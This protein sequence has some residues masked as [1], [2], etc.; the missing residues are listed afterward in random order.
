MVFAT[1]TPLDIPTGP[2]RGLATVSDLPVLRLAVEKTSDIE[3]PLEPPMPPD[4]ETSERSRT[5][6][7][8]IIR[9]KRRKSRT[10]GSDS[11]FVLRPISGGSSFGALQLRFKEEKFGSSK[12]KL[13]LSP[14]AALDGI[15]G[16]SEAAIRRITRRRISVS[17]RSH[18]SSLRESDAVS[19]QA[20][21]SMPTSFGLDIVD[22]NLPLPLLTKFANTL[23]Q[24][25]HS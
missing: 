21:S 17:G 11:P 6:L 22:E 24:P 2:K 4:P 14:Y 23:E 13:H 25:H 12:R 10:V 9:A 15:G 3:G 20:Q 7:T 8:R 18:I 19:N 5:P 16:G 1:G